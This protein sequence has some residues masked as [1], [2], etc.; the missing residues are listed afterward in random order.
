MW[1]V[2]SPNMRSIRGSNLVLRIAVLDPLPWAVV[3]GFFPKVFLRFLFFPV[4][5]E[6]LSRAA[7]GAVFDFSSNIFLTFP[8]FPVA[9]GPLPEASA[10]AVF[11]VFS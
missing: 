7:A 9:R 10:G 6:P 8:L 3:P 4:S 2:Y 11:G 5:L 1:L